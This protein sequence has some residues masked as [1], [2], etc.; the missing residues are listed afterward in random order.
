M[1]YEYAFDH[2]ASGT[3]LSAHDEYLLSALLYLEKS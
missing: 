2:Y 3:W 1:P